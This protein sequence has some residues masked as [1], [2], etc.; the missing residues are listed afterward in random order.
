MNFASNLIPI[1]WMEFEVKV[2]DITHTIH[3]DVAKKVSNECTP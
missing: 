2:L 1:N 3:C